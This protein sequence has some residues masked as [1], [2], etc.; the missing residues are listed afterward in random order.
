MAAMHQFSTRPTQT[1]P[2]IPP[3]KITL[4]KTPI[5][6]KKMNQYIEHDHSYQ[7]ALD[8]Q[9]KR[10]LELAQTKKLEIDVANNEREMRAQS[11]GVL[12]FGK[13]YDGYG[14]GKTGFQTRILYPQEKKRK[15]HH[16]SNRLSFEKVNEQANKEETLVPVRLDVE[17]DGYKIRDTFTWN[18]NESTITPD[19]FAEITC[20]D[21][22]LPV[23]IFVPLIAT[24]IKDQ[25][26]DYLTT[27]INE[28][29]PLDDSAY[30][31]IQEYKKQKTE[32]NT[33]QETSEI[34]EKSAKSAKADLRT[35][36]K[37]DIIVGNRILVDHFEWDITCTKNSPES[38]ANTI[39]TDLGLGGEFKTAIAHSIREQIHV[40]IKSLLLT[41]YEFDNEPVEVEDLKRSFLPTIY[42]IIRDNSN[43]EKFTPSLIEV[44][45]AEIAKIEKGR[46]RESRRKRRG[47]RSRKGTV[48]PD[49]EPI[50][51]YRTI[52]ASPPDHEMTDDQ[53]L[54]SMQTNDANNTLHSQRR[55]AVKARMNIAAEA[56]GVS[57][58]SGKLSSDNNLYNPVMSVQS[59]VDIAT[60]PISSK[61]ANSLWKCVDCGCSAFVTTT[62]RAGPSGDKSLCNACGLYRFKYNSAR[63]QN[64]TDKD[65]T[66]F[67]NRNSKY[68]A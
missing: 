29:T 38:F 3:G 34:N 58:T 21:L 16:Y 65:M 4:V 60:R 37:L 56:A 13:G 23:S 6:K 19:Q 44:T 30:K 35:V 5:E 57:L 26:Q 55:S 51:T 2:I 9:Y 1:Q 42:S 28:S 17:N 68:R 25:I 66:D 24:S 54:K 63:P 45:D 61:T 50:P 20:E 49:R 40:Y 11:R 62:I 15:R 7:I 22:R 31:V 48:L 14:N 39:A 52:L 41:G 8:A 10:H 67:Q 27:S 53:F 47:T 32:H 43:I 33:I 46:T 64:Y 59:G 18:I 36:I 12:I